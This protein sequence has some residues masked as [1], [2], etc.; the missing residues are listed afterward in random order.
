MF[1]RSHCISKKLY[2]IQRYIISLKFVVKTGKIVL[3]VS[4][5]AT[6]EMK[7]ECVVTKLLSAKTQNV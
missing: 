6:L 2:Y 4:E 1:N 7:N 3:W 5:L